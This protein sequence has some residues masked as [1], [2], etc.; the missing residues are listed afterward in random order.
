MIGQYKIVAVSPVGRKPTLSILA[1]YMIKMT[2][3]ID[4]WQLWNNALNIEDEFYIKKLQ[5]TYPNFIKVISKLDRSNRDYGTCCILYHYY[6]DCID[7]N[8]IYIRIDD[9][10]VFID[11]DKFKDFIQFR[12]DNPDFFMVYPIIINNIMIS[13]KLANVGKLNDFNRYCPAGEEYAEYINKHIDTIKSLDIFD[14]NLRVAQIIPE[15]LL[16]NKLYW[17]DHDFTVY[18]HNKFLSTSKEHFY[19]ENWQLDNYEIISNQCSSWF[20]KDMKTIQQVS[21]ED[22]PWFALFYPCKHNKKNA[23]FGGT[24]L[25]HYAYYPQYPILRNTDILDRYKKLA[26]NLNN[27]II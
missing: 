8:T 17:D 16:L 24:I 22:E 23:V 25:V 9:D 13:W 12:I 5:E 1:S 3:F 21:Q 11:T 6:K 2:S 15:N 19:M 4:E 10:V 14:P 27:I 26:L 7:E 20:G 18:M